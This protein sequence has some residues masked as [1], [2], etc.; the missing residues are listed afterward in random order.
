MSRQQDLPWIKTTQRQV[1]AGVRDA[2]DSLRP[3]CRLVRRGLF[4]ERSGERKADCRATCWRTIWMLWVP[5]TGLVS[6]AAR[7]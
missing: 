6:A 5:T 1:A 7:D 3:G 2:T 4:G